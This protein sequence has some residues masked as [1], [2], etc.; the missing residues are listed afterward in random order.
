MVNSGNK[1]RIGILGGTFDPIH[2]GHLLLAIEARRKLRLDSLIFVPVYLSPH[3]D[4]CDMVKA[5]L[6][7]KMIRLAIAGK[8]YFRA[9]RIEI[10]K[11]QVS[12]SIETIHALVKRYPGTE[13]FFI[14]G[15][16]VLS[17]L[18]TWKEINEIFNLCN[19]VVAMRPG[20]KKYALPENAAIL[21]GKFAD[22]SSSYVRQCL[23]KG[24]NIKGLLPDKVHRFI[25]KHSL[26][27]SA[28]LPAI[29]A[30]AG[31]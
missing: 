28:C 13:L 30:Q 19:F 11:P 31:R 4:R 20:F 25:I 15:S 16:D 7:Y 12:Y 9:S 17:E 3:K 22:I 14:V 24:E 10:D 8:K 26:Y 1:K 29:D 5:S 2:N 18:K 23:R 6:R 21:K 27:L